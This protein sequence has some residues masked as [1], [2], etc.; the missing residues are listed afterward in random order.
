M[1]D[2]TPSSALPFPSAGGFF[3][4]LPT[5]ELTAASDVY[6]HAGVS[7][8][9]RCADVVV[10]AGSVSDLADD[11]ARARA[12][13]GDAARRVAWQLV[14]APSDPMGFG[15]VVWGARRGLQRWARARLLLVDALASA[16]DRAAAWEAA[17]REWAWVARSS[18]V[19]EA[20]RDRATRWGVVDAEAVV[21]SV[22]DAVASELLPVLRF[23]EAVRAG[24]ALP[25]LP[26]SCLPELRR[27]A[28]DVAL[29]RLAASGDGP[30]ESFA[31]AAVARAA[32][33]PSGSAERLRVVDALAAA[34]TRVATGCAERR[35]RPRDSTLAACRAAVDRLP[36]SLPLYDAMSALLLVDGAFGASEP[37]AVA[38]RIDA[39]ARAVAYDPLNG[40]ARKVLQ[41]FVDLADEGARAART[42]GAMRVD[43]ARLAGL[44]RALERGTTWLTSSDEASKI[45]T[46]RSA[47]VRAEVWR[48]LGVDVAAPTDAA[49]RDAIVAVLE[50]ETDAD[51]W[52]DAG[53]RSAFRARA[54]ADFPVLA[55]LPWDA[56]LDVL[57]KGNSTALDAFA[58]LLPER[59]APGSGR[60]LAA[61]K[62]LA[63]PRTG[64]GA[65][66]TAPRPSVVREAVWWSS[67]KGIATQCAF[68]VGALLLGIGIVVARTRFSVTD[69]VDRAFEA[70]VASRADDGDLD[71]IERACRAY[72]DVL[73]PDGGDP[74]RA[75][76]E[77]TLR[78]L[79]EVR[80]VREVQR[81]YDRVVEA[82][83]GG[84][85]GPAMDATRELLR[86]AGTSDD[87]R[88]ADARRRVAARV[89]EEATV[90]VAA[91]DDEGAKA[92]IA[93]W[94]SVEAT[95]GS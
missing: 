43:Y 14:R 20:L 24:G 19:A 68:V 95:S 47:A 82:L 75:D 74:R 52:G 72:L 50:R 63:P 85:V 78:G 69:R 8:D 90:R 84:S 60:A 89:Y 4:W 31:K 59:R 38:S 2:A 73:G 23:R 40:S 86:L 53:A 51:G 62:P 29:D 81:A 67:P 93:R 79:P 32:S 65:R 18:E 94:R 27:V 49:A 33:L 48:R 10:G 30:S 15:A 88:V 7:H 66:P 54:V 22:L 12:V 55:R 70:V 1:A 3:F 11:V 58:V 41:Q 39:L 91:S 28:F 77:A 35:T 26:P 42:R 71:G 25:P 36:D 83:A 57:E 44:Q 37:T 13:I 21:R 46:A 16:G 87:T 9:V 64:V 5:L 61:L 34:W 92:L 76:V 56:V 80:R 17:D 6:A 45:S